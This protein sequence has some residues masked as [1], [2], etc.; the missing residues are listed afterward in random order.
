[1]AAPRPYNLV[2]ELTYRCPLRCA[3]CSNPLDFRAFGGELDARTWTRCFREAAELG[4][5]HVGL[6]GGE[7]TARSDLVEIVAGATSASLYSHLVTA[8]TTLHRDG[9]SDLR[10]AGLRS[11][12]LSFQDASAAGDAIAGVPAF[13]KKLATAAYVRDEGLPLTLNFVLHRRNLARVEDM[14]ELAR[15]LDADR[16]ELANVQFHGFALE[17]RDALMPAR[18]DL[19]AAARAVARARRESERPEILFVLPDYHADRPKPC[20]GGWG[21]RTLVVAPDGRVLPC[22]GAAELP[23]LEFWSVGEHALPACWAEAPGMN[24]YRGEAWMREP[25]RTCD[26]R[27]VDF[28]GCRCQAFALTGDARATDPACALAPQ[29]Q[30]V[31]N[32]RRAAE[33]DGGDRELVYRG[34]AAA[35][36]ARPAASTGRAIAPG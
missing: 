6:T 10:H 21:R 36:R 19:D 14:I 30:I 35:R 9:L 18:R 31:L 2:A 28:G 29:H 5:V 25:C 17:N 34:D 3:Y 22:Q 8:G 16:I 11:V 27:S 4:V 15:R 24:A 1:V 26:R 23:D 32:A 12:Q 13:D 33:I 20:M 7:P